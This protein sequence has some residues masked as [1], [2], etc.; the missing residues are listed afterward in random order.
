MKPTYIKIGKDKTVSK[1]IKNG[2]DIETVFKGGRYYQNQKLIYIYDNDEQKLYSTKQHISGK[3]GVLTEVTD[4][5]IISGTPQKVFVDTTNRG[6]WI[7]STQTRHSDMST[8]TYYMSNSNYHVNNG[9]AWVKIVWSGLTS[10]T[11]KYGSYGENNFDYM[12]VWQMDRVI[13]N[14]STNNS[15][16]NTST[17]P[18]SSYPLLS[19][20]G[21]SNSKAPNLEYTFTCDTGTHHVW[22]CYIKDNSAHS[23][24]DRGYIG[25]STELVKPNIVINV[26]YY[27]VVKDSY[28]VSNNK[29]YEKLKYSVDG[30]EIK[31]NELVQELSNENEIITIDD[32][33]YYCNY[34]YI[35][36]PNGNKVKTDKYILGYEFNNMEIPKSTSFIRTAGAGGVN[37]GVYQTKNTW[38][39]LEVSNFKSLGGAVNIGVSVNAENGIWG[40]PSENQIWRLFLHDKYLNF[41]WQR[42]LTFYE[43]EYIEE[44]LSDRLKITCSANNFTVYDISKYKSIYTTGS[45]GSIETG[46]PIWIEPMTDPG[47]SGDYHYIK[48]YEG[49]E[50]IRHYVPYVENSIFCFLE[51]LSNELYYPISGSYTGE[52]TY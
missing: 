33:K 8:T 10:F 45:N 25:I 23:F 34:Y 52:V 13:T 9:Q 21:K 30:S 51:V 31:G 2:V 22:I 16:S 7:L 11:L 36:L 46:Y 50:L 39:E 4:E 44:Y 17:N 14:F 5:S 18:T 20:Y 27:T 47:Y 24:D 26:D 28:I 49:D 6:D 42:G 32:K 48:I 41:M 40:Q 38:F 12:K 35:I 1:L 15:G 3:Y 29:Y 19:T 37:T 43:T